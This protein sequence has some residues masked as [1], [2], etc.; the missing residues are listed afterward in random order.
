VDERV[1]V[2]NLER[3]MRVLFNIVANMCVQRP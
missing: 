1:S 3:G 2:E